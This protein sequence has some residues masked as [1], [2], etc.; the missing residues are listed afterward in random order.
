M[1]ILDLLATIPAIAPWAAT[2]VAL[3]ALVSTVLPPPRAPEGWYPV[4]HKIVNRLALNVGRA[5]N[6]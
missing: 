6:L 3:C 1:D 2:I 5:R 4:F